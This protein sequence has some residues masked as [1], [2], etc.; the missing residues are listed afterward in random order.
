MEQ[1]QLRYRITKAKQA[2]VEI[3][4]GDVT[5]MSIDEL[6]EKY[7]E[8]VNLA[9]ASLHKNQW[10]ELVVPAGAEEEAWE[11]E[12]AVAESPT[13]P[14]ED[15][16][17]ILE[18]AGAAKG[19]KGKKKRK[20]AVAKANS[21]GAKAEKK[22]AEAKELTPIE[23]ALK[24]FST[25]ANGNARRK[26][27]KQ[28]LTLR[29]NGTNDEDARFKLIEKGVEIYAGEINGDITNEDAQLAATHYADLAINLAKK[30]I[31]GPVDADGTPVEV[32]QEELIPA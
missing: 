26:L 10:F 3:G 25:D 15:I 14:D 20:T 31:G 30:N 2:E 18:E 12:E 29:K 23:I 19:K 9:D 1:T 32:E 5:T 11:D 13:S 4:E 22:T 16:D 24:K 7:D 28:A 6:I 17:A 8:P 27:R 21:N